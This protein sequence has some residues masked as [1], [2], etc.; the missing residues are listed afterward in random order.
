MPCPAATISI[1]R[2]AIT[3]MYGLGR[4]PVGSRLVDGIRRW[5]LLT[6]FRSDSR[7]LTGKALR[8]GCHT[9]S[10]GGAGGPQLP[11]QSAHDSGAGEL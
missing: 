11:Y 10:D 2:S 1:R 4:C 7:T 3:D 8:S 9:Q 5:C 6:T